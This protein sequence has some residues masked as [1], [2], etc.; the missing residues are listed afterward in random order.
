VA[1]RRFVEGLQDGPDADTPSIRA[2]VSDMGVVLARWDGAIRSYRVALSAVGDSAEAHVA[3]GTMYLDR[4]Y[5]PDA[6]DQF[7]RATTT[8]PKWAEASLLLA[9]AYDA[10]GKRND[11]ARVLTTAARAKPDSAAIGYAR[12]QHAVAGGSEDEISRALLDFRD[13]HDRVV[14]SSGPSNS[15]AAPFVKLGLLREAPGLAPVFAPAPYAEGFRLLHARRYGDAVAAFQRALDAQ[16]TVREEHTRLTLAES[17]VASTRVE[18]AERA[19]KEAVDALP[20][21][22]QAYYRLARLYQSQSRMPEAVAAFAAS[23][24][25]AVIVG[26]DSLYETIGALRVADG[27]FAGAIAAYR[28]ELDANPNNAAA[29]RRLGDLYAQDG[30]LGESLAEYAASLSID[31]RDADAHASRAQTL[32]RLSRL[33]EAEAAARMAV[34][35]RPDHQA[36][37]YALG[38]A[39]MRT[40]RTEEGLSVLQEFERL[41]VATRARDDAAWQIKLLADQA[42]EHVARQEYAAAAGLLRHAA[43]YAPADGSIPLAAGALFM[44][45]GKFED[46][47]PLLKSALERGATDAQRYL[48]EASAA[49]ARG[50]VSR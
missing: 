2:A 38:T 11:A 48:A 9:L 28:L 44:K 41:Q 29:H 45:A 5:A 42:R 17:L 47:I 3:L 30:R 25:R 16:G 36:A 15:R 43:T 33:V 27:D 1:L 46:A 49:L 7:R 22:G 14:R 20:E 40:E 35:L 21:S 31:P 13:R 10:Q 50:E 23:S 18:D 24:E 4:G 37:Q 32:L 26:R 34:A 6:V 12:V 39:L 19:L 8:S